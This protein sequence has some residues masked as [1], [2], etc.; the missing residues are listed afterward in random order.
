M[1]T[2]H[3]G[4]RNPSLLKK[5]H[6][7]PF[8]VL[9]VTSGSFVIEVAREAGL[10]FGSVIFR[11]CSFCLLTCRGCPGSSSD[12]HWIVNYNSALDYNPFGSI[13]EVARVDCTTACC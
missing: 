8:S 13:P 4:C 11:R 6:L 7:A 5:D 1:G 10:I 3:L 12:L 9:E 2:G